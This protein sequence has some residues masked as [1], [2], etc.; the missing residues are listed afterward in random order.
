VGGESDYFG[1][2]RTIVS[3]LIL[4]IYYL[5]PSLHDGSEL[6][7]DATLVNGEGAVASV[8]QWVLMRGCLWCYITDAA[9]RLAGTC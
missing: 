4:I 8:D 3:L 2:L 5:V 1:T 6:P 7:E 9:R